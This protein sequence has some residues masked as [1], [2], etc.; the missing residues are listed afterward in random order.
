[1]LFIIQMLYFVIGSCWASFWITLGQRSAS[2]D[3]NTSPYSICPHCHQRLRAWQL[4]PVIGCLLQRG[5]CNYC[6]YPIN[7]FSTFFEML[8]GFL[9]LHNL[10]TKPTFACIA[11]LFL[12][13]C[14][15]TMSGTDQSAQ[16]INP[17]HLLPLALWPIIYYSQPYLFDNWQRLIIAIIL[18]I[19]GHFCQSLGNGDILFIACLF[20]F[21][22][23]YVTALTI[24]IASGSALIFYRMSQR[25]F[26]GVRLP[27]VPWLSGALLIIMIAN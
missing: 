12:S 6:H 1:M 22:G 11:V 26:K 25:S 7:P 3:L 21:S 19:A 10:S 14:L 2:F 16:W 8:T 20:A 23:L 4:L 24:L 5:H 17:L 18:V 13:A 27:F 9:F 15:L